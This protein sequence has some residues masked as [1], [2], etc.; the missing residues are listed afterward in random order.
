M[1]W[2]Y[3]DE[4]PFVLDLQQFNL[5]KAIFDVSR[6]VSDTRDIK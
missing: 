6:F 2:P 5:K 1:F 3:D 4:L